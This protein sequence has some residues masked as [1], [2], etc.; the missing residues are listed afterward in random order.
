MDSITDKEPG[1]ATS[2]DLLVPLAIVAGLCCFCM[3]LALICVLFSRRGR[4]RKNVNNKLEFGPASSVFGVT[5]LAPDND[6][7]LML[8]GASG[9]YAS[10]AD[11]SRYA[12][13]ADD[14]VADA[15]M[16]GEGIYG[17]FG[18]DTIS[19]YS[20]MP[21]SDY[22]GMPES[23]DSSTN[24]IPAPE[25]NYGEF[26]A[27]ESNYSG[28]PTEEEVGMAGDHVV[29]FA[30]LLFTPTHPDSSGTVFSSVSF[31]DSLFSSFSK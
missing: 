12:N 17:K 1:A 21:T 5:E 26:R 30:F 13:N 18:G 8:A 7:D 14:A 24:T 29:H 3:L 22:G 15:A 25:S 27:T 2:T 9:E 23:A 31:C 11:V 19:K 20:G 16:A 4:D 6:D 28:M 10:V